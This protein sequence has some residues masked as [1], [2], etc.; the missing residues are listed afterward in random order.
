MGGL[1][2]LVGDAVDNLVGVRT[3]AR[4]AVIFIAMMGF[5]FGSGRGGVGC[6]V[7]LASLIEDKGDGFADFSKCGRFF[8]GLGTAGSGWWTHVALVRDRILE[9]RLPLIDRR[10]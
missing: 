1:R 8:G 10:I 3:T 2:A 6:S 7:D 4:I 9:R 5:V